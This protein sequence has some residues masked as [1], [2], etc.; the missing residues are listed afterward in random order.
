[1]PPRSDRRALTIGSVL[2]AVSPEFPDVT[3]SKIRF[4]EAEGLLTPARTGS[5]YRTYTD[6]D[7]ERLRFVLRAQ[8]DRFWPLRVIREALDALDRGLTVEGAVAPRPVAPSPADDPDLPAAS[9]LRPSGSLRL[10][11]AELAEAAGADPALV[12]ELVRFGLVTAD[13][14]GHFGEAALSVTSAAASLAAY[15]M[16]P[17]HLRTFRTA[18]DREI[19][20]VE[21]AV[22]GL[23][24][25]RLET[26]T[27]ILRQCLALHAALVRSGLERG[28]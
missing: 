18:A 9:A 27:Q 20:L 13:P 25:D 26:R 5:G 24:D 1:M 21:Q 23:R 16:E 2:A 15:G 8:R 11:A 4:L 6:D 14:S 19:G 3:I 28:T 17:R 10:T 22:A 7:V 12:E